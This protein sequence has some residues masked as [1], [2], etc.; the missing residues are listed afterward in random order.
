MYQEDFF[1]ATTDYINMMYD[2]AEE[3][4][5]VDKAMF[6]EREEFKH[7]FRNL[8]K[9]YWSYHRDH[10]PTRFES[11]LPECL[12]DPILVIKSKEAKGE[13]P[14]EDGKIVPMFNYAGKLTDA[15]RIPQVFGVLSKQ[16]S[17]M[18]NADGASVK[19]QGDS[20][21]DLLKGYE[22]GFNKN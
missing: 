12:H 17:I 1:K 14:L 2:H 19:Q 3:A 22:E 6:M 15:G 8:L 7:M 10:L 16:H 11:I 4:M 9:Q 21:M 5:K 13:M 20:L 18:Y